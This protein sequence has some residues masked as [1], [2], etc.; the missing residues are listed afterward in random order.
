MGVIDDISIIIS[1][2]VCHMK[3]TVRAVDMGN[4]WS[5]SDWWV[6]SFVEF[7]VTVCEGRTGIPQVTEA[8]CLTCGA[9]AAADY[10]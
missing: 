7:T 3:E 1:C 5:G 9:A 2:S 6:P 10:V 8:T 4:R